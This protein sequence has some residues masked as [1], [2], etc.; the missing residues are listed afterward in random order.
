LIASS[1]APALVSAEHIVEL[2]LDG[3]AVRGAPQPLYL[4]RFIHGEIFRMRPDVGAI[5]HSHSPS[6]LPFS[7]VPSAPL[8]PICHMSGF[9][10]LGAPVFEIR[11]TAGEASDLLVSTPKL[12][13]ALA[14]TLGS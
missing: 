4:E 8:R 5:V 9:Q 10:S 14:T 1:K 2:D 3:N 11:E 6:V 12:G 7:V 13:R